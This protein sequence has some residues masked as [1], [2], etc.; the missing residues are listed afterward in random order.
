MFALGKQKK[1]TCVKL[2]L[3]LGA[4]TALTDPP[5]PASTGSCQLPKNQGCYMGVS[6]I[7]PIPSSIGYVAL[8]PKGNRAVGE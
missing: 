5:P 3:Q 6:K 4:Y 7:L 2:R 1:K 8:L